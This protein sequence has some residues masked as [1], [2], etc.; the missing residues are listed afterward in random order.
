MLGMIVL[1]L[2]DLMVIRSIRSVSR[3]PRPR[4]WPASRCCPRCSGCSSRGWP[5]SG[6]S[7]RRSPRPRASGTRTTRSCAARGCGSA[8]VA[9]IVVLA[10]PVLNLRMLGSTEKLCRAGRVRARPR[11]HQQPVRQQRAVRPD[12]LETN[13]G[14]LHTEVPD[15][16]R[17]ARTRSRRPARTARRS[18]RTWP[19][20]HVTG[21][22]NTKADHDFWPTPNRGLRRTSHRGLCDELRQRLG[23]EFRPTRRISAGA[24]SRSSQR[25]H[26]HTSQ[27]G[28]DPAEPY[29][30]VSGRLTVRPPARTIWRGADFGKRHKGQTVGAPRTTLTPR[31]QLVVPTHGGSAAREG[32]RPRS[33]EDRRRRLP[34]APRLPGR[35]RRPGGCQPAAT[36]GSQGI[37]RA[38]PV[39]GGGLGTR[40]FEGGA[41]RTS[42]RPLSDTKPETRV[43][44]ALP[45]GRADLRRGR[46][47][48]IFCPRPEMVIRAPEHA[49]RGGT[50]DPLPPEQLRVVRGFRHP[51]RDERGQPGM[52]GLV[53][54]RPRRDS[55]TVLPRR[56]TRVR[57]A[58]S[59][60][61]G[62][63]QRRATG[64]IVPEVQL[65]TTAR[66]RKA[67]V[68]ASATRSSRTSRARRRQAYVG[69]GHFQDFHDKLTKRFPYIIAAVLIVTFTSC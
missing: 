9:L 31:D 56:P 5:A 26:S 35:S 27:G 57:K 11:L 15:R 52:R 58:V 51:P 36:D 69:G 20:S 34:R 3:R 54:A 25:A 14:S 33:H 42:S 55:E 10:L 32:A 18:P 1:A 17:Q 13:P 45:Q 49:G 2:V 62:R 63:R 60:Q 23:A 48:T 21:A 53:A 16:A 61:P 47:L 19:P 6:Q 8:P 12:R 67:F 39:S 24:S 7:A 66:G 37:R 29:R 22:T 4:S 40:T 43:P 68:S 44:T 65:G 46:E 64:N 41:R 30:I 59:C 38:G 50:A 28:A